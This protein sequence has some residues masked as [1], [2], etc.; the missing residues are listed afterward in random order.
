MKY[1]KFLVRCIF[2]AVLAFG[3]V[4]TACDTGNGNNLTPEDL[5]AVLAADINAIKAGS[6]TAEGATVKLLSTAGSLGIPNTLTVPIGVTLDVTADGAALLLGAQKN[7]DITLTV[8]GTVIVGSNDIRFEDCQDVATINGS[9]VIQLNGKGNLLKVEGNW[10]MDDQKL[11]LDGVTLLGLED[12]DQALVCV[13]KGGKLVMKSGVITGNGDF[14]VLVEEGGNWFHPNPE[15]STTPYPF[16][17]GIFTME[18]GTISGNSGGVYIK[19][20]GGALGDGTFIMNSPVIAGTSGNINGNIS[21]GNANNVYNN[22]GMVNGTANPNPGN[23]I[24]GLL[25]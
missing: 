20:G 10:N 12:N 25:W 16:G 21:S 22:G 15:I 7:M 2:T 9:G 24:N 11:T 14:G 23:I 5:A 4:L 19:S 8:N 17:G 6:A 18:G 13:G 3:F 1:N